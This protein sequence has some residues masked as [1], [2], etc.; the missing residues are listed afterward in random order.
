M[1]TYQVYFLKG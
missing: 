1:K